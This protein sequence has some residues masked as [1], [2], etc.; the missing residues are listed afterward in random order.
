MLLVFGYIQQE[1]HDK[2]RKTIIKTKNAKQT[3]LIPYDIKQLILLYYGKYYQNKQRDIPDSKLNNELNNDWKIVCVF[4]LLIQLVNCFKMF[5]MIY[6][7]R[8][9]WVQVVLVNP[10]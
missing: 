1:K 4:P 7:Y 3:L 5:I 8:L 10:H 9:F 6:I 2:K